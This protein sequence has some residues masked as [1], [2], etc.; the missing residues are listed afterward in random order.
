MAE[1]IYGWDDLHPATRDCLR[2]EKDVVS[3]GYS[4]RWPSPG[5]KL[6]V[7]LI[8]PDDRSLKFFMDV[9]ESKR[10][11]SVLVGLRV[12]RKSTMQER[13]SEIPLLRVDYAERLEVLRHRNPDGTMV[14]G[15]HVHLDLDGNGARWAFPISSQDIIVPSDDHSVPALFWAFQDACGITKSLRLEHSLGV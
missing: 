1:K 14:V 8:S 13:R 3:G 12:D 7:E 2:M 9:I 6:S 4:Y 15:T 5:D 11:S 10:S